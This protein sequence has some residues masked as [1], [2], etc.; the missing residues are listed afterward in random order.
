MS[1]QRSGSSSLSNEESI[2]GKKFDQR[3]NLQLS[4]PQNR[5]SSTPHNTGNSSNQEVDE[6]PSPS[7]VEFGQEL[8]N[9]TGRSA[10]LIYDHL[11][12]NLK[13]ETGKSE[14]VKNVG[15]YKW[16]MFTKRQEDGQFE[17][18]DIGGKVENMVNDYM[19]HPPRTKDDKSMMKRWTLDL[20]HFFLSLMALGLRRFVID[21]QF[22]KR[23]VSTDEY[24]PF[25]FPKHSPV[26]GASMIDPGNCLNEIMVYV[27]GKK[28]TTT[29][30]ICLFLNIQ[31][32]C[33]LFFVLI[34]FF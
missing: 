10:G 4:V 26:G 22:S 17:F 28:I 34:C 16:D 19:N 7:T 21:H 13:F 2:K 33:I 23:I 6:F 25:H 27:M 3:T 18:M 8:E 20:Y 14:S 32:R 24:Q 29:I 30:F 9:V 1:S 15:M 12:E 31:L 11:F 5:Q